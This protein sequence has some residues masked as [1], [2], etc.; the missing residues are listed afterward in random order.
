MPQTL[1][2]VFEDRQI[3]LTL[4]SDQ[5]EDILSF[6][7]ILGKNRLSLS[8][9]GYLH[10]CHYVGFISMKK[11]RLQILPKVYENTAVN[12]ETEQHESMRVM[13]NLLRVSEFNNVLALPEQSSFAEQ[14]DIMEIFIAI[15]AE[16]VFHA[17]SRQ[18]NREYISIAENSNFIKGRID[19][20]A[21]LRKNIIRKD[22]HIVNFQ[23]F[24]HD[25]IL[26][27]II[28]TMCI[29]LL[30]LTVNADNKKNLKRALVFLDDAREIALSKD[31]FDNVKFTRLNMP[32][33]PVFEM[34]K[35]FFY[36]LTPQSYQGDDTICS[37]LIPLNELFELYLYKLFEAFGDKIRTLYQNTNIFA[38]SV[39][40]DFRM[41]IRPDII[42]EK[43][44]KLILI[45]DAKYKNPGYENGIYANINQADIYQI[46]AYSKVYNVDNIALIYPQFENS[47][48]PSMIVELNDSDKKVSLTI[49]CVDIRQANI[50]IGS[51]KLK[52]MWDT[53][54]FWV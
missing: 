4:T 52:K 21:N 8:C 37:F 50:A 36:N 25:N 53:Q 1:F 34:A 43:D 40:N 19:F 38:Q 13:L 10:V 31:L 20:S 30:R 29:K 33:K 16:K 28:K 45:A 54:Q 49:G 9:D 27:N 44:K 39:N 35:M 7:S 17:Y 11:T 48:T 5:E 15:F 26:N 23:S 46:F 32:F 18:M 47:S 12:D 22:L 51:E 42:L 2:T 14:S 6:R 3:K 41:K 24:E